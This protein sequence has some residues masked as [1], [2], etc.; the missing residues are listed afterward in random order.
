MGRPIMYEGF[1]V[2][3]RFFGVLGM[4]IGALRPA[5]LSFPAVHH[6]CDAST[7]L[8][9]PNGCPQRLFEL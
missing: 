1:P 4:Y 3:N 7:L 2:F 6:S 9:H 8:K 5:P